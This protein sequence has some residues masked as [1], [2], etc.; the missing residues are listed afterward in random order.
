MYQVKVERRELLNK[1]KTNRE[2]H[3]LEHKD[4]V[5]A[6]KIVLVDKLEYLL[7]EAKEAG[8]VPSHSTGLAYPKSHEK[9]YN[10]VVTMLEMS[11]EDVIELD[12][13][14]FSQYVMDE[15][16]WKSGFVATSA[17]YNAT[18]DMV[19]GGSRVRHA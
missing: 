6:Y 14:Q 3:I 18:A 13:N 5:E 15:W 19:A 11:V 1:V 16:S 2:K 7:K 4:A 10:Q 17:M 12:Q 8:D 9:D